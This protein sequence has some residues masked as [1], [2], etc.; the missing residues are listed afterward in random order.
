MRRYNKS[1]QRGKACVLFTFKKM[2]TFRILV[3][4]NI[5]TLLAQR[6]ENRKKTYFRELFES[7]IEK[8]KFACIL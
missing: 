1:L 6:N 3:V 8:R 4:Y 5:G 7:I 2:N